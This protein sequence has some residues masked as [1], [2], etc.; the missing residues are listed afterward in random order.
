MTDNYELNTGSSL[1]QNMRALQTCRNRPEA[2]TQMLKNGMIHV[3][4]YNVNLRQDV[5][6]AYL[7]QYLTRNLC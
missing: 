1:L 6:K 2:V 5:C 7:L 3:V 4:S